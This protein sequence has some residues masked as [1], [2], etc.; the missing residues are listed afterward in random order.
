MNTRET[1]ARIELNKIK[2]NIKILENID[3]WT[4]TFNGYKFRKAGTVDFSN[5]NQ[6][7]KVVKKYLDEGVTIMDILLVPNEV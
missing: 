1:V 4:E 7:Q 5:I 2:E 6:I 3:L